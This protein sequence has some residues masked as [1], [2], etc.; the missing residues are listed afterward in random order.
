MTGNK[1]LSSRRTGAVIQRRDR[2]LLTELGTMRVIDREQ[3]QL[4][5]GFP[6][7][8][9]ANRRLLKLTQAGVLRRIFIPNPPL[10]QKALYTLSPNGAALT[11]SERMGLPLRHSRFGSSPFLLH[12]LAINEVYLT[13][14]YRALPSADIRLARWIS[15]REPLSQVVPLIPDGYFELVSGGMVHPMFLEADLGTES[16]LIWQ[17]KTQLYLQLAISGKF[18]EL[19]RQP[20]FRVLVIATTDR[21]L[22][23]IKTTIAKATDKIFW[24]STFE[25]IK[26]LGFW[27]A[28]WMRPAGDQPFPLL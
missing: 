14:K 1:R 22:R 20:K 24:C 2:H 3:A 28:C 26:Q 5:M 16:L 10:G 6:G 9:R 11:G 19:F 4:V 21:R 12:R 25:Q 7:L 27:S 23:H 17:K 15:F 8:R 18:P 13:L